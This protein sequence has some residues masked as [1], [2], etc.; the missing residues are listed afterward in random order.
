MADRRAHHFPDRQFFRI[1][2]REWLHVVMGQPPE[3][4]DF[5]FVALACGAKPPAQD[6]VFVAGAHGAL[7]CPSCASAL[8]GYD[9]PAP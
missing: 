6:G 1:G 7:V 5:E 4:Q 8:D 2:S 9:R 3:N